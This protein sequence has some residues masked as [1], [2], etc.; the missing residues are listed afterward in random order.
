MYNNQFI[1]YY[2]LTHL[3]HFFLFNLENIPAW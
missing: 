2:S 3:L 1:K